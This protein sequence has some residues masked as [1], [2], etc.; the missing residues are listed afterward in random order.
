MLRLKTFFWGPT[1]TETPS[2]SNVSR[3]IS[4]GV[5]V[6]CTLWRPSLLSMSISSRPPETLSSEDKRAESDRNEGDDCCSRINRTNSCY[7]KLR[8]GVGVVWGPPVTLLGHQQLLCAHGGQL[9]A[10][11]Q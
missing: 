3:S 4:S 5:F 6:V 8:T 7:E 10:N 9:H 2:K 11:H 1:S